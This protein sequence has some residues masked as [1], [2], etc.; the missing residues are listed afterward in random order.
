MLKCSFISL[1]QNAFGH[2]H[3][4]SLTMPSSRIC[5]LPNRNSVCKFYPP[6]LILIKWKKRTTQKTGCLYGFGHPVP[7]SVDIPVTSGLSDLGVIKPYMLAEAVLGSQLFI[8]DC[9]MEI[10]DDAHSRCQCM[11]LFFTRHKFQP[12]NVA[13]SAVNPHIL[14]SGQILVMK[15]GRDQKSVVHFQVSDKGLA[16]QAILQ[17]C[18]DL[19]MI[20][21]QCSICILQFSDSYIPKYV[22]PNSNCDVRWHHLSCASKIYL[23]YNMADVATLCTCRL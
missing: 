17:Y 23:Y 1:G 19:L 12:I 15:L 5:I 14:W 7:R 2:P 22:S 4:S 11:I 6:H 18:D 3:I 10:Y 9:L 21:Q 8:H 13:L 16:S 20:H